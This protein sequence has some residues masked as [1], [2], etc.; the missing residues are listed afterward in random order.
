MTE[1]SVLSIQFK[2][3]QFPSKVILIDAFDSGKRFHLY[4]ESKD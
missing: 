3:D 1:S 4:S 2:I